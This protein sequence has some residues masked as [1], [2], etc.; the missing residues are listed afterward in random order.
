[1]SIDRSNASDTSPSF[2]KRDI[3][4]SFPETLSA[5]VHNGNGE[6]SELFGKLSLW[7]KLSSYGIELRGVQPVPVEERTDTRYINVGTWLGAAMI[8]LLP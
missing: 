5:E 2:M 1:M 3:E 6:T 4:K 7:Q 8:C